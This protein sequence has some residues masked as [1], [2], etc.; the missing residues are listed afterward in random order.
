MERQ[1][2]IPVIP[3]AK[4]TTVPKN[5]RTSMERQIKAKE[6]ELMSKWGLVSIASK[7]PLDAQEAKNKIGFK[8][9][10]AFDADWIK[11]SGSDWFDPIERK[12][13]R[14]RVSEFR[15]FG[16]EDGTIKKFS[17]A[18]ES[19]MDSWEEAK[20]SLGSNAGDTYFGTMQIGTSAANGK[21]LP[22][23]PGP[24]TR[25]M[26][27]Y[28]Q[29]LMLARAA[30]LVNY[31]PLAKAGIYIKSA[32]T[33]GKGPDIIIRNQSK[34]ET[35]SDPAQDAIDEYTERTK[36]NTRLCNWDRMLSTNGEFF[37]EMYKNQ[38]AEPLTKSIDPGTVYDIVTEPRDIDIVYGLVLMYPTRYQTFTKGAKGE[39]VNVSDFV[40]ETIPPDNIFHIKIN[41]Q[42]NEIRGR[43][44]LLPVM[45]IADWFMDYLKYSVL[46]AFVQAAF[47]WDVTL[48]NA[49]QDDVDQLSLNLNSQVP[50]PMTM[51]VHND[52][53]EFK[54][55][56]S[57][58]TGTA[59]TGTFEE[60][61]TAFCAG[62]LM[63]TEYLGLSAGGSR[64]TSITKTE[65]SIKVFSERR[66]VWEAP[67]KK[68]VQFVVK[69][70][71]GIM[72]DE[73]DIEVAWPE[74]APENVAEKLTNL[75][76]LLQNKSITKR[77]F[78]MMAAKEMDITSY[79]W[80]KEQMEI[81]QEM[82]QD[83]DQFYSQPLPTKP[84]TQP[85]LSGQPDATQ[86]PP[87]GGAGVPGLTPQPAKKSPL[88]VGNAETKNIKKQHTV[89]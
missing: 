75:L 59:K 23:Q 76:I 74:I 22:F 65:P 50:S 30:E 20:E 10:T 79:D 48:K 38:N 14:I 39:V 17:V 47:S 67:I 72:L 2:V 68:M 6:E 13:R 81:M 83:I 46:K 61:V 60:V 24:Y 63:P 9:F 64:A 84:A 31:N 15:L 11:E 43:S 21:F 18:R 35:G 57:T 32:F 44:D 12:T 19:Y 54:P 8:E 73:A 45:N 62:I 69:E 3:K 28:D 80:E 52:Q 82:A 4:K 42:E 77:R 89:L 7:T 56:Q 34:D 26:Y 36:F 5:I 86:Q 66:Q 29:W 88:G 49:E 25:Q 16:R 27:I 58:S 41:V 51:Q 70:Q 78:D 71:T 37:G 40:Y 53:V 33:I 87:Q 85:V 1:T 55:M